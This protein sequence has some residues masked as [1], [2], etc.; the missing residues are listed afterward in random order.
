[1]IRLIWD[2]RGEDAPNIARH[3]REHLV[4]HAEGKGI[5]YE[6]GVEEHSEM[7][8]SAWLAVPESRMIE[9]RDALV[10]HRGEVHRG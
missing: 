6:T 1:M 5:F 10:P 3:H 9:V 7:Y 8:A 4:E 2:F